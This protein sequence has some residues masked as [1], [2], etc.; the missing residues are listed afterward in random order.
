[1]WVSV[2]LPDFVNSCFE[3]CFYVAVS[4]RWRP[5]GSDIA[6]SIQWALKFLVCHTAVADCTVDIVHFLHCI[7]YAPMSSNACRHASHNLIP[8]NMRLQLGT[9]TVQKTSIN[10]KWFSAVLHGLPNRA[11]LTNVRTCSAEQ[12]PPH[13]RGP[14]HMRKKKFF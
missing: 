5:A 13:F 11:G 1:M 8:T 6:T 9:L 2:P 3:V 7:R 4:V 12:G 14:P 10:W